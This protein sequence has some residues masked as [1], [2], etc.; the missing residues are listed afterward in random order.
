VLADDPLL[1]VR[2][3][4]DGRDPTRVILDGRLRT[5]PRARLLRS[6]SPARTHIVTTRTAPRRKVRALEAAGAEVLVLPGTGGRARLPAL[7][8]ALAKRDLVRVLV[9][10]GAEVHAAFL[11]AGLADRLLLY[12]APLAIG[13]G[14][15][16][17]WLGGD[18]V[19]KLGRAPRF[20]FDTPP[21]QL[22][23]DLLLEAVPRAR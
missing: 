8:R 1:T 14:D 15:A 17:A 22:G 2:G 11:Q 19:L 21:A 23:D 10:G 5:P 7:A 16:P 9:E 13:G 12:L 20:R 6:G 4:P 18:G 3:I